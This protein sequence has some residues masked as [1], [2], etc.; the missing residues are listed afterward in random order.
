MEADQCDSVSQLKY[1]NLELKKKTDNY[2]KVHGDLLDSEHKVKLLEDENFR[3]IRDCKEREDAL[4]LKISDLQ[5]DLN[6]LNAILADKQTQLRS[7]D[8]ELISTKQLYEDK[9]KENSVLR[10]EISRLEDELKRAHMS[11]RDLQSKV[12]T[13]INQNQSAHNEIDSLVLMNEKL[14][15]INNEEMA[16][17]RDLTDQYHILEGKYHDLQVEND[18]LKRNNSAKDQQI[19]DLSSSKIIALKEVDSLRGNC[20]QYEVQLDNRDRKI[21]DMESQLGD[22][23]NH[24]SLTLSKVESRENYINTLNDK[25]SKTEDRAIRAEGEAGRLVKENN[26]LHDLLDKYRNDVEIHKK[27]REEQIVKKYELEQE[28]KRLER[29]ALSKDIEARS[30]KRE[31]EKVQGTKER[32]V[33]EHY[34]LNQELEALKE[35]AEV[36]ES[37]NSNVIYLQ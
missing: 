35:H 16:K 15:K 5:D 8:N 25:N 30:A 4:K 6:R 36:L 3:T 19:G 22:L 7:S 32:L 31:L 34:Q 33:G 12:E 2:A 26:T 23:N 17:E 11:N 9:I 13:T 14:K 18:L 10:A 20:A 1:E 37:Q 24:L 27:L 28:K 29:E 21:K